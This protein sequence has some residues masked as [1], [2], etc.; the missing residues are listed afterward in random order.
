MSLRCCWKWLVFGCV[1]YS[2]CNTTPLCEGNV[3]LELCNTCNFYCARDHPELPCCTQAVHC[4][5]T[6]MF[7]WGH[8][9]KTE[10]SVNGIT[11]QQGWDETKLSWSTRLRHS[12]QFGVDI[13]YNENLKLLWSIGGIACIS[14]PYWKIYGLRTP[15]RPL[16][17][18]PISRVFLKV[19]FTYSCFLAFG[20]YRIATAPHDGHIRYLLLT[21]IS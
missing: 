2:F 15:P 13:L 4:F 20:L 14:E 17:P 3:Y 1:L 11:T 19:E 9:W 16:V 8:Q 5:V 7:V 18:T 12:E 6:E 10:R 21:Y